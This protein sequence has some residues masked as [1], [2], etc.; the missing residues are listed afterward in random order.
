MNVK[1]RPSFL[2]GAVVEFIL[3]GEYVEIIKGPS[4]KL[5]LR[6]RQKVW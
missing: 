6:L 3:A 1:E 2:T 4:E 5:G